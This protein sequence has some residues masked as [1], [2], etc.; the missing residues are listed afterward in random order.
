MS[1]VQA[2]RLSGGGAGSE[3]GIC[4]G[5]RSGV[6]KV[7]CERPPAAGATWKLPRASRGA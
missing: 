4:A 5:V 7:G 6:G 1:A 3:A 2:A